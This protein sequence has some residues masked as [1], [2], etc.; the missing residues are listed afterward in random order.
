[1]VPG[2]IGA[3]RPFFSPDGEWV[4]FFAG[5]ELKKVALSGG[6][7]NTI[8]EVS[9]VTAGA[10]WGQDGSIVF[11]NYERSGL[12]RVRD[13]GESTPQRLTSED[14]ALGAAHRLPHFLPG[15]QALVFYIRGEDANQLALLDLRTNTWK[16][17]ALQGTGPRY[18]STG[19]LLFARSGALLAAPFDVDRGEVVGPAVP[20]LESVHLTA[21]MRD[22]Y[23]SVSE[24]GTLIYLDGR[25][26]SSVVQLGRDG[27]ALPL[28]ESGNFQW[29]RLSPDGNRLA[30]SKVSGP[31]LWDIWVYDLERGSRSRLADGGSFIPVWSS[32]AAR[33][34][35]ARAGSMLT[36]SQSILS[37]PADGSEAPELLL[38]S[39]HQII[40]SSLSPDDRFLAYYEV[41]P[42]SLRDLHYLDLSSGTSTPFLM[43]KFNEREPA[44]SPNGQFVAYTSDE[45]GR[46][47]VYVR[48]FPGPG[49]RFIVST[50][51]G[52]APR[53]SG[54]G[55]QLFYLQGTELLRVPVEIGRGF[56][57]GKPELFDTR[58]RAVTFS[59]DIAHDGESVIL[60]SPGD[61]PNELRVVLNF[62][63][64]LERLVPTDK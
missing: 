3:S 62:D 1:M 20:V 61:A 36:G 19:H 45:S 17:L 64:E 38:Q 34:V 8:A 33:L 44:F 6:L 42:D 21:S 18:L 14:A 25:I 52:R 60:I 55:T 53:W 11:A 43:T 35:F 30:V 58:G 15:G 16:E 13:D 22:P 12:M 10:T 59:Y 32:D 51:G 50:K 9:D 31:G 47:E 5:R 49:G 40:P 28:T 4:G 24:S 56:H 57:A 54:D 26:G 48:P 7:P 46:D 27:K 2:T 29:P 39:D 37:G 63:K 23:V 41:H